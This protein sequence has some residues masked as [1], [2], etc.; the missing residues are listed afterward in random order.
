MALTDSS[1]MSVKITSEGQQC[2]SAVERSNES[3]SEMLGELNCSSSEDN[4]PNSQPAI[5]QLK[6][7][8]R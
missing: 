6:T 7:F 3:V 2:Y 1:K 4:S 8:Q 5:G